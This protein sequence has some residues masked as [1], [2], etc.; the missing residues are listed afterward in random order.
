[1]ERWATLSESVEDKMD[2]FSKQLFEKGVIPKEVRKSKDYNKV[3]DTF[4]SAMPLFETVK[5]FQDHCLKLVDVL[6][7]LGGD[8][9]RNGIALKDSWNTAVKDKF[10][11]NFLT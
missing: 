9:T 6:I 4:L 10:G 11:I 7:R 2:D 1:M 5:E 3:M 8:A